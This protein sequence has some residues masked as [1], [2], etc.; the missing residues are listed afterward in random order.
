[1]KV[2]KAVS[3]GGPIQTT[4]CANLKIR[5]FSYCAPGSSSWRS[6]AVGRGAAAG[7][8]PIPGIGFDHDIVSS[9]SINMHDQ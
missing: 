8:L 2:K 9:T 6:R 4:Q 3:G 7:T 1:M 5:G